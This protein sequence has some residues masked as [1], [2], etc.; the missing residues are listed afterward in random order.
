MAQACK[1]FQ[2]DQSLSWLTLSLSYGLKAEGYTHSSPSVFWS[3]WWG[4]TNFEGLSERRP[5]IHIHAHG[6][7][8]TQTPTHTLTHTRSHKHTPTHIHTY[9]NKHKSQTPHTHTH[10][11]THIYTKLHTHLNTHTHTPTPTCTHPYSLTHKHTH[12]YRQII[13][14]GV[15]WNT[16]FHTVVSCTFVPWFLIGQHP[17]VPS[18]SDRMDSCPPSLPQFSFFVFFSPFSS[19]P[20]F[21]FPFWRWLGGGGGK[22]GFKLL[23]FNF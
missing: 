14:W 9:T 17:D 7:T 10:K 6:N 13:S 16:Q 12:T 5:H 22:L 2:G 20:F 1:V 3:N 11:H 21:L 15:L 8:H 18:V 4:S 23:N 19:F